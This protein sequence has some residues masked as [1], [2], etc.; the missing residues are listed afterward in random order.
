MLT[1][2]RI[3]S[4]IQN[5][6][7]HQ[8]W[9][10]NKN[11]VPV[12]CKAELYTK[13]GALDQLGNKTTYDKLTENMA[14]TRIVKLKYTYESFVTINRLELSYTEQTYLCQS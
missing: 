5:S 12:W 8:A 9:L 4:D 6:Q 14:K 10:S 3:C 11:L 13:K 7:T 1:Q 2:Q